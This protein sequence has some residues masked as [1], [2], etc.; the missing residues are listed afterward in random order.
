MAVQI[1]ESGKQSLR[2]GLL[3]SAGIPESENRSSWLWIGRRQ[4]QGRDAA[5]CG[6][7]TERKIVDAI[8]SFNWTVN[9]Q[10]SDFN[11]DRTRISD[12]RVCENLIRRY[13]EASRRSNDRP[14][15]IRYFK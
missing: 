13:K 12:M 2:N 15:R 8:G 11:G 9:L 5:F 6:H 4:S 1:S 10:R 7:F 14:A 3:K